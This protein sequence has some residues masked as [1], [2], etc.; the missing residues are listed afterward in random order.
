MEA[1]TP[2]VS[3]KMNTQ[4][5]WDQAAVAP[6]PWGAALMKTFG[7]DFWRRWYGVKTM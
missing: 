4:A 2:E 6:N 3:V 1:A 5:V 7:K